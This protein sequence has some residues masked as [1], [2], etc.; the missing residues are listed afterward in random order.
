M[1]DHNRKTWFDNL[2]LKLNLFVSIL[3]AAMTRRNFPNLLFADNH[4]AKHLCF[5][6]THLLT[7]ATV[8]RNYEINKINSL[9]LD[10]HLLTILPFLNHKVELKA[11]YSFLAC[12][13]YKET[14]S[15]A[16]FQNY[17]TFC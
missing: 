4:P 9:V 15:N 10:T 1:I 11:L 14:V 12:I 8:T 16:C 13:I 6:R 7:C 3:R 17:V 2:E 5:G